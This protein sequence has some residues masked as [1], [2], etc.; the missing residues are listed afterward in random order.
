MIWW[1]ATFEFVI[2]L[3]ALELIFGIL[4][5]NKDILINLYNLVI[6]HGK[7]FIYT[8]NKKNNPISFY[9]FLL[10]LKQELRE[11]END[12]KENNKGKIFLKNWGHLYVK[13]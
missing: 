6:L 7:H 12:Y 13:I 9:N 5:F 8:N 2:N 10:E 1:K 3:T 4:N 11:K